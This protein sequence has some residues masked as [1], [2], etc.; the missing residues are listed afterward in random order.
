MAHFRTDAAERGRRLDSWKEI[1]DYLN[2]EVRSVQRWEAERGLPIHRLPGRGRAVVFAY[3]AEL[4]KW[5]KGGGEAESE[6]QSESTLSSAGA[7]STLPAG[8][9]AG[10][11]R[12]SISSGS[13]LANRIWP[14]LA[15]VLILA[16]ACLVAVYARRGQ[17]PPL[18]KRSEP[19]TEA[20]RLMLAVLPFVNLSSNP[21][22]DYF[23]DGLTEEMIT[24]LGRLNPQA[25]G[26]I[27]RTSAMKYKGTHEDVGQI[28]RELG[29]GYLLEGSVRRD[30]DKARISAQLIQVSDQTHLWAHNYELETRN[31]LDVEQN[32]AQA[33]ADK[34]LI[35]L[36]RSGRVQ[37]SR[38]QSASPEAYDDY[39]KGLYLFNRRSAPDFRKSADFFVKATKEAPNYA[40]AY[41]GLARCYAL[42][43]LELGSAREASEAKVAANRAVELDG[44]SAEAFTALAGV[45]AIFDYD[46]PGAEQAFT[47]A[48]ALNPNYAPA[49][50]W[51]ANLYLDPQGRVDD[52]VMEMKRA[53]EIDPLSLII[54]TDL[55]Y[56]Y[57]LAGQPA[58]ALHQYQKVVEMDPDF[59]PAHFH[60]AEVYESQK[61]YDQWLSETVKAL[62]L[63]GDAEQ[64][65]KSEDLYK[66][67]GYRR[68]MAEK[69][70][71]LESLESANKFRPY[72]SAAGVYMALGDKGRAL[73]LLEQSYARGERGFVYLKVDPIWY[74]IH[75]DPRFQ[76]LE[77]KM[78]LITQ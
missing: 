29:V 63:A 22:Q 21:S 54:N 14:T 3:T 43:A 33:I 76:A 58:A 40:P 36:G 70:R 74:P 50:H 26:V 77:S 59:Y 39:L 1:A 35:N 44:F 13:R 38:A 62:R 47:R 55:G 56:A 19:G 42:L 18:A 68:V 27:A 9:E 12:T 49:H 65:Q 37:L 20:G 57:Y 60:L 8:G 23:A 75:S 34:I 32:V 48:L 28:G 11:R 71:L 51:Y 41:G 17:A 67:G 66:A 2:R 64:A 69:A 25:L 53:Q 45:R 30:G 31:I 73:A 15:V 5:M 46:W 16:V 61:M 7:S 6:S 72:G 10:A 4:D 78:G 52:A 24:D